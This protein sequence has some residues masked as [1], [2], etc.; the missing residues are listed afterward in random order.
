MWFYLGP[1]VAIAICSA[2]FYLSAAASEDAQDFFGFIAAF[3]LLFDA[4][5]FVIAICRLVM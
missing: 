5:M 4:V 3:M 2:L 1:W